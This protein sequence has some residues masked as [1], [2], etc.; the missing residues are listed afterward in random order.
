MDELSSSVFRQGSAGE[1]EKRYPKIE[2]CKGLLV[3]LLPIFLIGMLEA[4]KEVDFLT[5]SHLEFLYRL[6]TC[7]I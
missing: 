4:K 3:V 1:N 2:K 6:S 7:S 5:V